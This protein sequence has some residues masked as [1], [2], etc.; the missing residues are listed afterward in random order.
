[1][2]FINEDTGFTIS[3][4]GS[5]FKT[6]D[7]GSSWVQ[8]YDVDSLGYYSLT[9]ESICFLSVNIGFVAG[10]GFKTDTEFPYSNIPFGII[11]KTVNGGETWIKTNN[12]INWQNEIDYGEQLSDTASYFY[13]VC[14]VDEMQAY[15]CGS[16]SA[17]NALILET[18][19][20]G[21]NWNLLVDIYNSNPEA[22]FLIDMSFYD[23]EHGAAIGSGG[24]F[25]QFDGSS[26]TCLDVGE[27]GMVEESVEVDFVDPNI[28]FVQYGE[29]IF[30]VVY[31][32]WEEQCTNIESGL[33][34]IDFISPTLG[35]CTGPPLLRTTD[36]GVNWEVI[37]SPLFNLNSV[38][39]VN[40]NVGYAVGNYGNIVKTENADF[41]V[42]VPQQDFQEQFIIKPNP[43]NNNLSI[44]FPEFVETKIKI[45]DITGC[46]VFQTETNKLE[47]FINLS[48]LNSGIYFLKIESENYTKT[49]RVIKI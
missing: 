35:Y 6:S 42:D 41:V 2:F 44:S 31:G 3:S 14:F 45:F 16:T 29:Q 46:L 26:W 40:S 28:Y 4:T 30:K 36:G 43:F 34:S 17:N 25:F 8:K 20:G 18:T 15:I 23:S 47:V 12:T 24:S 7:G 22:S 21:D 37:D 19:N 9:F 11:L 10:Y 27:I 38:F 32:V 13:S 49:K 5:I 39:L 48:E 1:M 33:T